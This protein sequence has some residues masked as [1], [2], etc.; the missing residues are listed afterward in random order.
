VSGCLNCSVLTPTFTAHHESWTIDTSVKERF[1]LK[2]KHIA[3]LLRGELDIEAH[4]RKLRGGGASEADVARTRALVS[5]ILRAVS[6]G[7]LAPALRTSYYRTAFQSS[8]SNAV[9]VSLDT[10]LR[11]IDER[12]GGSGFVRS[13]DPASPNPVTPCDVVEFP[14]AILEVKLQAEPPEWVEELLASGMLTACTKFSKFLH[15][16][17][18]L[19]PGLARKVPHWWDDQEVLPPAASSAASSAAMPRI[20]S[21]AS[22]GVAAAG[23]VDDFGAMQ[24]GGGRVARSYSA[25][26]RTPVPLDTIISFAAAPVPDVP[27]KPPRRCISWNLG[28]DAEGSPAAPAKRHVPIKARSQAARTAQHL[29]QSFSDRAEDFFRQVRCQPRPDPPSC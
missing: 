1:R 6:T 10:Q 23:S 14:Y 13:L 17:A 15:G 26:A 22:I 5:D 2:A 16:S 28:R 11:M 25:P 19:R 8:V 24:R 29:T 18:A 4:L 3:A 7:S 12:V 20:V 21:S 9:R 27:V